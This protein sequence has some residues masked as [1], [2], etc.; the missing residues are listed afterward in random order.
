[1]RIFIFLCY[2]WLIYNAYFFICAPLFIYCYGGTETFDFFT[3]Y[4]ASY[5]IFDRL[6]N[7]MPHSAYVFY[8]VTGIVLFCTLFS[9]WPFYFWYRRQTLLTAFFLSMT[10]FFIGPGGLMLCPGFFV[11]SS[12]V[13]L[14]SLP[15]LCIFYLFLY[16]ANKWQK[17]ECP[18]NKYSNLIRKAL[19]WPCLR[20]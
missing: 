2:S 8:E 15:S 1:M 12:Y 19:K 9:L 4:I 3:H 6:L 20:T 14:L 13:F 16:Y 11:R 5:F 18:D 10:G 17:K 7:R